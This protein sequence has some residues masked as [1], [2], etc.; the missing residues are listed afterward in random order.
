MPGDAPPRVT[1]FYVVRHAE[2][3]TIG[4]VLAGRAP[5]LQL[6]DAG[7]AAAERVGERLG[8]IA[9]DAVVSSPLERTWQTAEA[10]A[11]PRALTVESDSAWTELEPGEWTGRSIA[12]LD[13]DRDPASGAAWQAYNTTRSFSRPP[14]G[15][16][17]LEVQ[18][19][20]VD[21]LRRLRTRFPSGNVVIVSHAE[22][23]RLLVSYVLGAPIDLWS[24]L[25]VLPAAVTVLTWH[26]PAPVLVRLNDGGYASG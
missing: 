21:G 25:E 12:D 1:T 9:L 3:A 5:G 15:E 22:P 19:R 7:R 16:L 11:R 24:R 14:N 26:G 23:I 17:A 13:L 8:A 10:I 18:L 20:M 6:T 2:T 4:R